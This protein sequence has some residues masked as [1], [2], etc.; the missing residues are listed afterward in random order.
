MKATK[1]C[2]NH[3]NY[4]QH[5]LIISPFKKTSKISRYDHLTSMVKN[6]LKDDS[7]DAYN[8]FEKISR[9]TKA[10]RLELTL[11]LQNYSYFIKFNNYILSKQDSS[12][13]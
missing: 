9:Q 4:N 1:R 7:S 8:E 6:I 3:I 13:N 11:W 10:N 5:Y 12:T 2:R